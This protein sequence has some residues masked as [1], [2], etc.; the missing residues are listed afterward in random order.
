[1]ISDMRPL[2]SLPS[3]RTTFRFPLTRFATSILDRKIW[4]SKDLS[5]LLC[6]WRRAHQT[7]T[8]LSVWNRLWPYLTVANVPLF[9]IWLYLVGLIL[10]TDTR[11]APSPTTIKRTFPWTPLRSSKNSLAVARDNMPA[12]TRGCLANILHANTACMHDSHLKTH[13][14]THRGSSRASDAVP[15]VITDTSPTHAD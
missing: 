2:F 13:N 3:S 5:S 8:C 9:G 1:M 12:R 7:C 14:Q 11:M 10:E 15:L 6:A 4:A